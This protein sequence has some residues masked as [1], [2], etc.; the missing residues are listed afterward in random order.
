MVSRWEENHGKI[1]HQYS[2]IILH[3][4]SIMKFSLTERNGKNRRSAGS[5]SWSLKA[6]H[7]RTRA[8]FSVAP[9][10]IK[11]ML[12]WLS[13]VSFYLHMLFISFLRSYQ[14]ILFQVPPKYPK[15]PIF[16]KSALIS[17]LENFCKCFHTSDSQEKSLALLLEFESQVW[18]KAHRIQTKNGKQNNSKL[19]FLCKACC[20][21]WIRIYQ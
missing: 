8:N 13:N 12:N 16:Q 15:M 5:G 3:I 18:K 4:K 21:R 1:S 20:Y 11:P 10:T 7:W 14:L 6:R 17:I 19:L 2:S 9:K